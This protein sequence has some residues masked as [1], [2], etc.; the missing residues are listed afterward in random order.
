MKKILSATL[1]VF[2][3]S[4]NSAENV[5]KKEGGSTATASPGNAKLASA[6]KQRFV[7]GKFQ[8]WYERGQAKF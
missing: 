3:F 8:Q 5:S 7:E 4:C 2:L 6:E 1:L